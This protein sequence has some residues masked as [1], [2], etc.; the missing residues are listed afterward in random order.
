[1]SNRDGQSRLKQRQSIVEWRERG[2]GA[3]L[4]KSLY[5]YNFVTGS[6]DTQQRARWVTSTYSRR[7]L[8]AETPVSRGASGYRVAL[9]SDS[10]WQLSGY[11]STN[12]GFICNVWKM[13]DRG[14][15]HVYEQKMNKNL[16]DSN[17][18]KMIATDTFLVNVWVSESLRPASLCH[19]VGHSSVSCL[20]ENAVSSWNHVSY[21]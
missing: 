11:V 16:S 13:S 21:E 2:G 3:N 4:L 7:G 14:E 17:L 9:T 1:M 12:I 5:D 10:R 20:H 19:K 6:C 15:V 18:R 8:Y